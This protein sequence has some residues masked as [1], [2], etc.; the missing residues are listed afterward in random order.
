MLPIILYIQ[1][2]TPPILSVVLA[3]CS[4]V[5]HESSTP[6][7]TAPHAAQPCLGNTEQI[8]NTTKQPQQQPQSQQQTTKQPNKRTT[9]TTTVA[10]TKPQATEKG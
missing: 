2:H 9:T 3:K 4:R 8:A 1:K 6:A 5:L 10:T 7:E